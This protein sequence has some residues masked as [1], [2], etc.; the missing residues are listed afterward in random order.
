MK[1]LP[2]LLVFYSIVVI[3]FL[4]II[5]TNVEVEVTR[6]RRQDSQDNSK[7]KII[8]RSDPNTPQQSSE[9]TLPVVV[10]NVPAVNHTNKCEIVH[11]AFVVENT[12]SIVSLMKS[13]LINR[14]SPLHIHFIVNSFSHSVLEKLLDTWSLPYVEYSFYFFE[15]VKG[16][17]SWIPKIEFSEMSGLMKLLLPSIL[18]LR[19]DRVIVLDSDVLVTSDIQKLWYFSWELQKNNKLLAITKGSGLQGYFDTGVLLFDLQAM[20][21]MNWNYLWQNVVIKSHIPYTSESIISTMIAQYPDIHYTLPCVWNVNYRNRQVCGYNFTDY[22]IIQWNS[23]A[24]YGGDDYIHYF[25][26]LEIFLKQYEGNLFRDVPKLCDN[27]NE[28][29]SHK[30]HRSVPLPRRSRR[31]MCRIL[32]T[33]SQQIF[34]TNLYYHGGKYKP[35]DEYETTLVTQLSL[36]RLDKFHLL[37]NHWDGPISI[38]MYGTDAQAWN[39]TQFLSENGINRMNMAIHIVYKQGKFYPVNYLRNIALNAVSTPYV[40]LNDGDF[41]PSF[42]LFSYLKKANKV[43]MTGSEKRALV[44]PAFNGEEGFTYPKD[45]ADLQEMLQEGS[46][47]MFCVWCAHQ[48]HGPTNYSVWENTSFPYRVEWAFHYEPYVVVRSDIVR[49]DE[50]FVGYGWNKVSQLTEMKA[51][52]YEFVVLPDVFIIHSPHRRS[53]D[54]EIWKRKNF[55]FCINTIWKK[56]IQELLQKYGVDCLKEYKNP[57]TIINIKI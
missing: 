40:F 26:K 38:T 52:G 27:T 50:R 56:F 12:T 39:L 47:R 34:R 32:K 20:R 25:H 2:R 51:Q 14:H 54:R 43:L 11:L 44:I 37:I 28:A 1:S 7:N 33:E 16:N 30:Q 5:A 31:E 9:Q 23:Q 42:G 18:P 53:A 29:K 22:H 46:V 10:A 24:P 36:D 35:T 8:L 19:V 57:P 13:I 45:K 15:D 17:I 55:K 6:L 48:T 49:Y 41:L 21:G 3:V 4:I